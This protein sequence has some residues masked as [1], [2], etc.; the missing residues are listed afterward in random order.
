MNNLRV[1]APLDKAMD[2][3]AIVASV[4]WDR[5]ERLVKQGVSGRRDM[6]A[7]ARVLPSRGSSR[8]HSPQRRA[9]QFDRRATRNLRPGARRNDFSYP[10][11]SRRARQQHHLWP[12]RQ[13]WS[14][15]VNVALQ[16]RRKSKPASSGSTAPIFSTRPAASAATGK[17]A[18]AAK[19]D[20]RACWST[21]ARLVSEKLRR[22]SAAGAVQRP[23][24]EPPDTRSQRR[25]RARRPRRIDRTVKLF[26][27]GKRHARF[28]VC[29]RNSR[30][31]R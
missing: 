25:I 3:G 22:D 30:Q 20:A 12:R 31:A 17:A 9:S 19:A 29:A 10:A 5:I 24:T 16:S 14:E 28:G 11:R 4:Q 7:A 21:R 2:I 23:T 26:I 8:A 15:N 18:T 27:G 13:I 1:G 6:L